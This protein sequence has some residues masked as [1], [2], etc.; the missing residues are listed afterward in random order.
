MSCEYKN[1]CPCYTDRCKETDKDSSRCVP[2][3]MAAYE[4]VKS[5]LQAYKEHKEMTFDEYLKNV[6]PEEYDLE[7]VKWCLETGRPVYITGEERTGTTTLKRV[8]KKHGYIAME[9]FDPL[10]IHLT[11]QIP[12]DKMIPNYYRCIE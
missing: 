1:E 8:L 2:A 4:N 10:R 9:E 11:K 6:L 5:E 12:I 3:L 7:D